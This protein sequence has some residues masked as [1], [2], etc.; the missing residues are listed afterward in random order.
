VG[1]I[2]T[3]FLQIKNE[4]DGWIEVVTL[5]GLHTA[6]LEDTNPYV[7]AMASSAPPI[8]SCWR[9]HG[10]SRSARGLHRAADVLSEY[11]TT[12]DLM[13]PASKL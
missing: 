5:M 2:R 6:R 11:V 13:K 10:S 8:C 7:C 9:L 1:G 12:P 3:A 4:L